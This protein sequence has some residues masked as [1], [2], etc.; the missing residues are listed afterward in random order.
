[1][2]FVGLPLAFDVHELDV[3]RGDGLRRRDGD[4]IDMNR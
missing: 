2:N 3:F 1:M 4:A